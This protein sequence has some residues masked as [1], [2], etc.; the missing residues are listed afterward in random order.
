MTWERLLW[1][2]G[3]LLN[4]K[5]CLY[6]AMA[7][8]FDSEGKAKMKPATEVLLTLSLTSGK[9]PGRA[10]V[11]HYNYDDAHQYLGVIG[12]RQTCK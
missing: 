5:K 7:R 10:D 9:A 12:C 8:T 4:L 1:T 2:S 6:Y 3:G 11:N